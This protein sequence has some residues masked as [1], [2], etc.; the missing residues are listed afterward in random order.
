M[1]C[2]KL[3]VDYRHAFSV[4][5]KF[6]ERTEFYVNGMDYAKRWQNRANLRLYTEL[7]NIF[8]FL[9]LS[10]SGLVTRRLLQIFMRAL[11]DHVHRVCRDVATV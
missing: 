6:V 5:R 8:T 11:G 1:E 9:R 10:A 3:L 2:H 4:S 7:F